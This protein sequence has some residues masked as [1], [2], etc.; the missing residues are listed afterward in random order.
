MRTTAVVVR[1][2]GG[3]AGNREIA[4]ESTEQGV[5]AGDHHALVAAVT[6]AALAGDLQVVAAACHLDPGVRGD[7]HAVVAVAAAPPRAVDGD[8]AA[9]RAQRA[10][11]DVDAGVVGIASR[12]FCHPRR[13]RRC[14][15]Q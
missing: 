11:G 10:S 12:V 6:G 3:T 13:L 8:R 1:R 7:V 9:D 2:A 5:A 14:R 15:S 4:V